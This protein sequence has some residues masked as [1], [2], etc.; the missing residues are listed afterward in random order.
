MQVDILD[1]RR[2]KTLFTLFNTHLKSH[3]GDHED[4]GRANNAR[5]KTQA[6]A[7]A[8]ILEREMTADARFIVVGDMNDPVDSKYLKPFTS[9]LFNALHNPEESR[10]PKPESPMPS[11]KA[12]THRWV[13]NGVAEHHLYDQIWLSQS[14]K[15][16]LVSSHIDRRT[17]HGGDGSDHDP[18][19]IKLKLN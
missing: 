2:Q 19:W 17:K 9:G 1:K 12:W 16:S 4:N 13:E 7:I 3:F 14:L 15:G 11:T 10:E 5:R 6:Q 18:A 8:E